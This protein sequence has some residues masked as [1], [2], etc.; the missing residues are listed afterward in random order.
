[1]GLEDFYRS[2]YNRKDE[3]SKMEEEIEEWK[4]TPRYKFGMFVK[5]IINGNIFRRQLIQFFDKNEKIEVGNAGEFIM[6]NRAWYWI[7]EFNSKDPE[8]VDVIGFYQEDEIIQAVDLC[9]NFFEGLEEFEKCA[10][11]LSIKKLLKKA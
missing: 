9:V 6:Y 10:H 3:L 7:K 11:F 4:D 8:W 5:L 2:L 1:M